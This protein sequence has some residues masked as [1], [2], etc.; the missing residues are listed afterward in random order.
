MDIEDPSGWAA[1]GVAVLAVLIAFGAWWAA[2]RSAEAS[3]RS[4]TASERSAAASEE[5]LHQECTPRFTAKIEEV[6]QWRLDVRLDGPLDLDDLSVESLDDELVFNTGQF[7]IDK[8]P[9]PAG[10][11][12]AGGR[13][14]RRVAWTHS[15]YPDGTRAGIAI[16]ETAMWRVSAADDHVRADEVTLRMRA[17]V[18]K[19]EWIVLVPV[20]V[21]GSL[22]PT[23]Y[24]G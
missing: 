24:I 6:S 5:L 16:G 3:E 12:A 7:G 2:H 20:V 17:R 22:R 19:E 10:H 23:G 14:G 1:V 8:E 4:A 9:V 13:P 18:G 15:D 11:E 21:P